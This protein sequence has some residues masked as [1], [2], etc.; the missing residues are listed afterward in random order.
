MIKKGCLLLFA[1]LLV[2]LEMAESQVH[3]NINI[4]PPAPVV[5]E[6]PPHMLFLDD[7]G[8]YVAVGIPY[9]VFFFGGQ[10][11]YL[12]GNNWFWGS[13]Y[14]GPWTYVEYRSL[15]PGL[16]KYQVARLR[17][18]REREYRS[19]KVQGEKFKGKHF[20]AKAAEEDR[21]DDDQGHGR[22]HGHGNG[23]GRGN[24]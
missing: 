17:E 2:G 13:G 4:G 14:R 23:R 6:A 3:V 5:V 18:Y 15:P 16:R 1:M 20:Y 8:V 21:D 24:H 12:H 19:Y 22:G 7:P 9:D 11:Y 10:Y